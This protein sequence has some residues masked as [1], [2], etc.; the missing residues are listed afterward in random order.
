[1]QQYWLTLRAEV[2]AD[3]DRAEAAGEDT[4]ELDELAA[5]L[6]TEIT[7]SRGPRHG[8][9]QAEG[10]EGEGPPVQVHPAPPGRRQTPP[11]EGRRPHHRTGLHRPGRQ[12]LPAVHVHHA[13]LRQLR[14]G[15]RRRHPGRPRLRTTTSGPR[16]TRCTSPRWWTGSSRTC[17][18]SSA[19]TCS[20]SAP[21]NRRNGSRRT[22]TWP[23]A[24]ACPGRC[25]GRSSPPPT[26]RSGGP[27]PMLSGSTGTSCR[28]GTR[29]PGPTS[30]RRPGRCCLPGTRPS[31]PSAPPTRRCMWPGSGPSS[32]PRACWP[33]PRTPTGASAT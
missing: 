18:G 22:S 33:G 8:H 1:M 2:Q 28:S 16:G 29:P 24:A 9:H 5:E 17:A 13:D 6:D 25:C 26:T 27:P 15:P 7:S 19:T 32:T 3:R 23:S 4:T 20:T 11:S 21:S 10:R 30:T 12:A 31:T 14:Q